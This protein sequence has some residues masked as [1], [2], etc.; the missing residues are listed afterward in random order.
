MWTLH[1]KTPEHWVPIATVASFKR[2]QE[3]K[4]F[5]GVEWVAQALR[6]KSKDLEVDE[7]G[8]NVRR[9]TEVK[10]INGEERMKRSV[11]AV[12]LSHR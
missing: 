12:S 11:Y 7:S 1:S 6:E 2:M 9:K 8:E 3:F 4:T 5:G 10:E